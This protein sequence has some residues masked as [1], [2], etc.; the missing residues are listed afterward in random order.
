MMK[1]KN[2]DLTW[3]NKYIE[4]KLRKS[5]PEYKNASKIFIYIYKQG[6]K[7]GIKAGC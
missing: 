7:D 1:G 3:I 6:F 5:H 4:R 2:I